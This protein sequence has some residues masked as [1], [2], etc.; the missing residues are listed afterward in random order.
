MSARM[1]VAS[2]QLMDPYFRNTVILM[3]PDSERGS[4]GWVINRRSDVVMQEVLDQLELN[5]T[6]T[7]T[8]AVYWGGPVN[9]GL[10]FLLYMGPPILG[11]PTQ[12]SITRG[13]NV[14]T[15][16]QTLQN[17]LTLPSPP[18]YMLCV[19]YAGWTPGLVDEEI[20][21]GSW[22]SVDYD[23]ALLMG[24]PEEVRWEHAISRLGIAKEHIWMHAV[25]DE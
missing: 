13:L 16:K 22:I 6:P 20:S 12:I 14:S 3:G 24:T 21:R 8:A 17:L 25:I 10:G 15:S 11:D 2:P 4:M 9:P 7:S 5:P 19:G 23:Q 1:L 18:W